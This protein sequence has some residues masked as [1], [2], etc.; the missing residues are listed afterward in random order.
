M[1]RVAATLLFAVAGLT[2]CGGSG[3]PDSYARE[4]AALLARVPVYPGASAPKTSDESSG[5]TKFSARDWTL[6]ARGR[7]SA[8]ID[9]YVAQL[10]SR[11]WKVSGRSFDTIRATRSND[12]LSVGVRGRRLEVVAN[13]RG[14]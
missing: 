11:G 8:V 6:P 14:A 13:S 12:S 1:A 5:D 4:N 3:K 10:Q 7:A 9:W 2:A